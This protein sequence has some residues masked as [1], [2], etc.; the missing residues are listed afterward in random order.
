L[1]GELK[2]YKPLPGGAEGKKDFNYI[3]LARK[4][5]KTRFSRKGMESGLW[6]EALFK[7]LRYNTP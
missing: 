4:E 5:G 6:G 7:N 3:S 2:N 1:E